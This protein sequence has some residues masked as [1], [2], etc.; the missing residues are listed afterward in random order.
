MTHFK[1]KLHGIKLEHPAKKYNITTKMMEKVGGL[2]FCFFIQSILLLI[3]QF[4]RDF[5]RKVKQLSSKE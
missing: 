3:T 1:L 2:T 5:S 4:L